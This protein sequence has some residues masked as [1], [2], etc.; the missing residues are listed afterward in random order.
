MIPPSPS[1]LHSST[2]D[3][4]RS[5]E[6]DVETCKAGPVSSQ[7]KTTE[8]SAP[9]GMVVSSHLP[10]IHAA[11]NNDKISFDFVCLSSEGRLAS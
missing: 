7:S 6:M 8:R 11:K 4:F 3:V 1:G 5:N 2:L 9:C 10:A